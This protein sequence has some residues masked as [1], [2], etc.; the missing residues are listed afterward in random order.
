M[1]SEFWIF[2]SLTNDWNSLTTE[3][4]V[5]K[6]F[7]RMW[8]G[9]KGEA[10]DKKKSFQKHRTMQ[11]SDNFKVKEKEASKVTKTAKE[12]SYRTFCNEINSSTTTKII[13]NKIVSLSKNINQWDPF[14]FV[15][16][17]SF[18]QIL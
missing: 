14:P 9:N 7:F 6:N 1:K 2:Q 11:N 16:E 5:A 12:T 10:Q 15:R 18:L 13:W 8:E 17:M 3:I 4:Q